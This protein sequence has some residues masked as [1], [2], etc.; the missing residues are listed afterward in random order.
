MGSL[1]GVAVATCKS[2]IYSLRKL[3]SAWELINLQGKWFSQ[4]LPRLLWLLERVLQSMNKKQLANK[5]W[6]SA[7]KMRGKIEASEYKDF[8]L[9][10]IFYKFLSDRER[11]F[12]ISQ[13]YDEESM[14]SV[15]E[16]NTEVRDDIQ[17]ELGY[18]IAYKD[19]FSTWI[20][21]GKDFSVANVID[22]LSAFERL[23]NPHRKRLFAGIFEGLTIGIS[24]LG[25]NAAEQTRAVRDL[26]S[27]I[28]DIPT[29]GSQDYD[30]LGFIY[31]YLISNFAANAG[32]KAG[33][34][35]TPHEV[36][37]LMSDIIA[38]HLQEEKE[39]CIYDPTSGSGSL[40]INIG[41]SVA[42]YVGNKD[43]IKYYAQEYNRTTYNLT[44]MNLIMRG[45]NPSNIEVRNGD[46]LAEDWPMFSEEDPQGTYTPL[47]L[48]A[49]VSNPPYSQSWNPS[50]KESD[51]RYLGFGL[52][53]KGCADYAFL[54][55]DLYHVK[56]R[57]IMT[58]VL[59]HGVLYRGGSEWSIRKGL[60]EGNYIDAIIGLPDNVFFGT[61]IA[62]IVMVLKRAETRHDEKVLFV[63]ASQGFVKE[64]KNNK[65]RASD[66]KKIVDAVTARVET[67]RYAKLIDRN[68]IRENDYN[69]N[70]TRY[71]DSSP[72]PEKY[73]IYATMF[74]GVPAVEL[75]ALELYWSAF[76]SLQASLFTTNAEGYSHL[77]V[78]SLE[79]AIATNAD[80]EAFAYRYVKA[81]ADFAD[82][83]ERVLIEPMLRLSI[84]SCEEAISAELFERLDGFDLVD[85]YQAYQ[86][87]R[88][89]WEAVAVDLEVLQI[90]GID[91]VRVV[92]P[93]MILKK[94]KDVEQEVQEGWQGRLLPFELVQRH[95]L[96]D[97]LR[98][99]ERLRTR[100]M[101]IS[102]ELERI[103][104][105]LTPEEL[106]KPILN[107]EATRFVYAEVKREAKPFV[108]QH[109]KV[110]YAEDSYERQ[111]IEALSL[112]DEEKSL[113]RKLK[114]LETELIEQ[115][116][117]EIDDET[118][119]S[120]LRT[121]WTGPLLTSLGRMP[122]EVV[123]KLTET[124]KKLCSKYATTYAEIAER[125][126]SAERKLYDL[127][128]ELEGTD[129]DK[130]G[131]SAFRQTL[132]H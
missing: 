114:T 43:S 111:L 87:F 101:E 121:K 64:G 59:P 88:D 62:T 48:D 26:L 117:Q 77:S 124:L 69:L 40:L 71:V 61:G 10:F 68:T 47:Y 106:E 72:Q 112:L 54:L 30:V 6:A 78:D 67:P 123:A 128:G 29:D 80:V 22:A 65:L 18:F 1:D 49:V 90:E 13:D 41:K 102:E 119:I 86:F 33:E 85:P 21:Q 16:D 7:N 37:V 116:I 95:L 79:V 53:P 113:K 96:A 27:L 104:E 91:A 66:I 83:L 94:V 107:D 110:P 2:S 120:L 60:I 35:Y 118:A 52:A 57:G 122:S 19:L 58:I 126:A 12:L 51:P 89:D 132:K 81:F 8:I 20:D 23:I 39:I 92:D 46:T 34:F 38:H 4:R 76:P 129:A 115:T 82:F 5:I 130:L 50:D 125:I 44:R 74:G 105:S 108:A 103:I 99:I 75:S 32:K 28:R 14:Q 55:H 15:S 127:L 131:L 25:S 93:R 45:V 36:S 3:L 11:A 73:D 84:P 9:G 100:Q 98:V 109:K 56:P 63:D 17:R 42:R 70:I 97:E 31:E 24:K